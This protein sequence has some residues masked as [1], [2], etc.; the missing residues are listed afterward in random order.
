LVGV[1]PGAFA[2]RAR[3]G[4]VESVSRIEGLGVVEA[5]A[6]VV[7]M[8]VWRVSVEI[9]PLLHLLLRNLHLRTINSRL[10]KK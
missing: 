3:N 10:K 2:E 5:V 4:M 6:I 7:R 9:E 8:R 1:V